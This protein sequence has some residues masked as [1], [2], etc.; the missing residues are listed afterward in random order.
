MRH[1]ANLC[2]GRGEFAAVFFR[3]REDVRLVW[4]MRSVRLCEI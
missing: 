2:P 1:L 4:R 3:E